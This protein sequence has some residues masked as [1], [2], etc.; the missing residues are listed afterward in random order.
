M[1]KHAPILGNVSMFGSAP[2]LEI[3]VMANQMTPSEKKKKKRN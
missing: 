3:L 2:S 1:T